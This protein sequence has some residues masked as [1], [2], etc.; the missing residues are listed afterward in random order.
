[1]DVENR[2]QT[3]LERQ[4]NVWSVLAHQCSFRSHQKSSLK[5]VVPVSSDTG[6]PT[7]FS[8]HG[9]QICLAGL[10]HPSLTGLVWPSEAGP[11]EM[12]LYMLPRFSSS[13][14]SHL[15]RSQSVLR[16]RHR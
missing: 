1:M 7:I 16:H 2:L 15:H 3:L 8:S 13:V 12:L 10:L 6:G 11:G 9:M 4:A 5:A 14:I